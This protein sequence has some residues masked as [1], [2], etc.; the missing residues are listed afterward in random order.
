M[1][2]VKSFCMRSLPFTLCSL[3]GL[4]TFPQVTIEYTKKPDYHEFVA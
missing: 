3:A 1:M 4:H 2:H